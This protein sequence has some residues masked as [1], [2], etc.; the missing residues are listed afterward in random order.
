LEDRVFNN[1][2][3]KKIFSNDYSKAKIVLEKEREKSDKFLERA[4]G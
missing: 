4:L 3:S 2:I 1:K